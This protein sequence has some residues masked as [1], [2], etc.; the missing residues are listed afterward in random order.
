VC[1]VNGGVVCV[2]VCVCVFVVEDPGMVERVGGGGGGGSLVRLMLQ[3][4]EVEETRGKMKLF[5]SV[6]LPI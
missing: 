2:C 3:E 6:F 1:V 5:L 4:Q